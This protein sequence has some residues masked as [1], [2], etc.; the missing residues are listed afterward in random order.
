MI[1]SEGH[2]IVD[3]LV[4]AVDL[5]EAV[6]PVSSSRIGEVPALNGAR[7]ENPDATQKGT[8]SL[9]AG[10]RR[11]PNPAELLSG[12]SFAHLVEEATSN[13]DRV[14]IDSA[15]ILAVSDTLLMV[16]HVQNVCLVIRA[17][18][19][20]RNTIQRSL[21]LLA[22]SGARPVGV[23]LNRLPRQ[24]GASY[25]YYYAAEGYGAGEGSY[26]NHYRPRVVDRKKKSASGASS[27][28]AG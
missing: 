16:P 12:N 24:R 13:F 22:G 25:Y 4:G 17:G 11:A 5:K 7:E 21:R 27:Q 23:V 2:G 1:V 18:H 10:G 9:L 8:L 28:R 6:R 3:C 19:S 14:V 20:P 26:S 15:P